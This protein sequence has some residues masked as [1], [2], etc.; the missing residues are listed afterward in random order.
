LIQTLETRVL[1]M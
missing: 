1:N